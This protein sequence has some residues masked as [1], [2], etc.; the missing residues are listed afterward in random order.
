[1]Q[2]WR[3]A[4]H[5]KVVF[6]PPIATFNNNWRARERD[7]AEGLV[8]S[9]EC[10]KTHRQHGRSWKRCWDRRRG[11]SIGGE[12][13]NPVTGEV[14]PKLHVHHRLKVPTRSKDEHPML[15]EAR[16]LAAMLVGADTSNVPARAP[17][18]LAGVLAPQ[19]GAEALPHRR[20]QWRCRDR[21][22]CRARMF[23]RGGRGRGFDARRRGGSAPCER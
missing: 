9:T 10:D 8:L 17:D 20:L 7:L 15:K 11:G 21:S 23:A 13:T 6:C 14:E 12:W 16:R 22:R 18:P 5:E 2:S 19:E 3:H 4:T 1:M